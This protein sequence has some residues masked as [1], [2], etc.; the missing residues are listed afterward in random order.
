MF[1]FLLF[2]LVSNITFQVTKDK[3][4]AQGALNTQYVC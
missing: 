1:K 3:K 4:E 2:T